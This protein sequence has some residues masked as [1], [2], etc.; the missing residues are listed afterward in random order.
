MES[1]EE[2]AL[3]AFRTA[4][5]CVKDFPSV[6]G[7]APA[8]SVQI[9]PP[10][11]KGWLE[12]K[13]KALRNVVMFITPVVGGAFVAFGVYA[14]KHDVVVPIKIEEE[15]LVLIG[16]LF[17]I[18]VGFW[19]TLALGGTRSAIREVR[20]EEW[21]RLS[22]L[23][24]KNGQ[25]EDE[26]VKEA[27]E[28]V[29]TNQTSIIN[30]LRYALFYT[31]RSLISGYYRLTFLTFILMSACSILSQGAIQLHL[32]ELPLSPAQPSNV[33]SYDANFITVYKNLT[34]EP[35][36]SQAALITNSTRLEVIEAFS[37]TADNYAYLEHVLEAT[38]GFKMPSQGKEG[39]FLMQPQDTIYERNA[40]V[41]FYTDLG[42]WRMECAWTKP[43]IQE[44]DEELN[45]TSYISLRLE[46]KDVYGLINPP[47]GYTWFHPLQRPQ[48]ISNTSG[49]FS[50]LSAFTLFGASSNSPFN[51]TSS[52]VL[53]SVPN[54]DLSPEWQKWIATTMVPSY[55]PSFVEKY[56][57]IPDKITTL[58]CEPNLKI[59]YNS[60]VTIYNG[61]VSFNFDSSSEDEAKKIGN[62]DYGQ[63]AYLLYYSSTGISV[64]QLGDFSPLLP[65]GR[66]IGEA[67]LSSSNITVPRDGEDIARTMNSLLASKLKYFAR[68][69]WNN[70]TTFSSP[71]GERAVVEVS[72]PQ[73]LASAILFA[74]LSLAIAVKMCRTKLRKCTVVGLLVAGG[75]ELDGWREM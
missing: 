15:R 18:A 22:D 33:N 24:Q 31:P 57:T 48:W 21:T 8:L 65:I 28:D 20:S 39:Y 11:V 6:D 14:Y 44:W 5:V 40:S 62:L 67:A 46:D 27:L 64:S 69:S 1:E 61:S 59:L 25:L 63:L 16:T 3:L 72:F 58:V 45:S 36:A 10:V 73:F 51:T 68:F 75:R 42:R 53:D 34:E 41:R 12:R 37:H 17:T 2:R 43:T 19:R 35:W 70:A 13:I 52:V 56:V 23:A 7:V 26:K 55:S 30:W 38:I 54:A 66:L 74:L 47:A 32:R 71:V 50:G 60:T 4:R 49:I 9:G 29:S